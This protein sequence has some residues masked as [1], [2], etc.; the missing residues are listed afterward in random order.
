M[1][2]SG[3]TVNPSTGVFYAIGNDS[4]GNSSLES[5]DL[6]G[7]GSL[8][9]IGLLGTG[10]TS[11]MVF[12]P[13]DGNLYALFWRTVSTTQNFHGGSF[14]LGMLHGNHEMLKKHVDRVCTPEDRSLRGRS[15]CVTC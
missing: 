9:D 14:N 4:L 8:T 5:F 12:D 2:F 10:F 7:A 13:I 11:G 15:L 1:A 3:L 6:S